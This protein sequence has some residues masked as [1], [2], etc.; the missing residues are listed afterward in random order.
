M[1]IPVE[2]DPIG[3]GCDACWPPG[4]TPKYV[5]ASFDG[6]LPGDWWHA[7]LPLP[8]RGQFKLE[9]Q[10]GF[11]CIYRYTGNIWYIQYSAVT[12][13]PPFNQ[14]SLIIDCIPLGGASTFAQ[15]VDYT[16]EFVFE[17]NL[18]TPVGNF[19]Y[20]GWGW[21]WDLTIH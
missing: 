1:G 14:S 21:V 20:D 11:P 10:D 4:G 9:Q 13:F 15:L 16:C 6:I 7:G 5:Y 17:N 8:P 3:D 2:P 18:I 19:Y 12:N